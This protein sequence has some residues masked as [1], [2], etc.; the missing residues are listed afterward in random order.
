MPYG[1]NFDKVAIYNFDINGPHKFC[2]LIFKN[3]FQNY[4]KYSCLL[5]VWRNCYD[6]SVGHF[7]GE[8]P[9]LTIVLTLTIF[10]LCGIGLKT[11]SPVNDQAKL[12]VPKS[13]RIVNEKAWVDQTFPDKTR[14]VSILLEST[15]SVL[16]P[17]CLRAVSMTSC[18]LKIKVEKKLY[19]SVHAHLWNEQKITI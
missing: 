2:L 7:V 12:W 19:G 8:Y 17:K 1:Y 5:C 3:R 13:S 15:E 14:F 10:G 18:L 9:V 11:L 4:Q 6:C 16:T